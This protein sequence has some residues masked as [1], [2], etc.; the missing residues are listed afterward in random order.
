MRRKLNG[1]L[2]TIPTLLVIALLQAPS[3]MAAETRGGN[4]IVIGRSETIDDDL[5]A[6]GQN[7]TILGTVAGSVIAGGNTVTISGEVD[8]D[9]MAAGG[10]VIVDGPV[11]GSVRAAGQTVQVHNTVGHDVL[12]T[13]NSVVIGD[14]RVGRDVLT[15]GNQVTIAGPVARNVNVSGQDIRISSEI[16]GQVTSTATRLNLESGAHVIGG[17]TYTSANDAELA[18]GAAVDGP[19]IR[20]EPEGQEPAPIGAV[21]LDVVKGFIAFAVL[22]LVL[23]L[24][25]P[26]AALRKAEVLRRSPW[27]SL[28]LGAV[29]LIG[30]PV[31]AI[32][33]LVAAAWAGTWWL[34]LAPLGAYIVWLLL[35]YLVSAVALGRAVLVRVGRGV[36]APAWSFL[37]GLVILSALQLIPF[38]GAVVA[39]AA[40]LFG[41]GALLKR[42]S[43]A[44]VSP[45]SDSMPAWSPELHTDRSSV[46]TAAP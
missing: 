9:V 32:L 42:A 41:S 29:V 5:Y 44:R 23:A 39:L 46:T 28:G 18:S 15:T 27:I 7:V 43:E 3:A 6:L 37:L 31:L 22:G 35:G 11:R 17:L 25:F 12:A 38:V 16:G 2:L 30:A 40:V 13:A 33:V 24:L 19:I 36:N 26:G 20:T 10:T 1:L 34:G 45:D 4:E 21:A 14:G 8:G